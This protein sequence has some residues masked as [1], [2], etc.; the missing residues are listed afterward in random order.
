MYGCGYVWVLNC[1]DVCMCGFL[2]AWLF[3]DFVIYE[4]VYV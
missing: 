3:V 2:I 1:V 4:C